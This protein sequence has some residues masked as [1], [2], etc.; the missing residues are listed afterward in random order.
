MRTSSGSL[1]KL[2]NATNKPIYVKTTNW[3]RIVN[4]D[5]VGLDVA[6]AYVANRFNQ[7]AYFGHDDA[8]QS[9]IN[10]AFRKMIGGFNFEG[11]CEDGIDNDGDGFTDAND[12]DCDAL[13][14]NLTGHPLDQGEGGK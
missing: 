6:N 5:Q 4:G 12:N 10:F 11:I 1:I 8:S 3:Y 7:R 13:F 2:Y 14:F 9:D